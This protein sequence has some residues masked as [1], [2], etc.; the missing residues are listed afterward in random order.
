MPVLFLGWRMGLGTRIQAVGSPVARFVRV[1]WALVDGAAF[2]GVA[3]GGVGVV[4]NVLV[5]CACG[6]LLFYWLWRRWLPLVLE[7]AS[8]DADGG[9]VLAMVMLLPLAWVV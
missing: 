1:M 7:S 5:V 2:G 8:G 6:G 3:E 9:L 4:G